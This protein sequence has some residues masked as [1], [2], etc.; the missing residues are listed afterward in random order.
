VPQFSPFKF[1]GKISLLFS[2]FPYGTEALSVPPSLPSLEIR[3]CFLFFPPNPF[4]HERLEWLP[5]CRRPVLRFYFRFP[6]LPDRLCQVILSLPSSFS[7]VS[8]NQKGFT[9]P[10]ENYKPASFFFPMFAPDE[11]INLS[12]PVHFSL[13]HQSQAHLFAPAQ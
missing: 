5:R 12:K 1:G 3:I 11:R 7:Q 13:Q 8:L 4:S 10:W 6:P 2:F 9:R